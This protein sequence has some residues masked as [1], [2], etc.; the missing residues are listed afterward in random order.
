MPPSRLVFV[1]L[2]PLAVLMT[3]DEPARDVASARRPGTATRADTLPGAP[4]PEIVPRSGWH[5]DE[6]AAREHDSST[7]R[8]RTVF[9]HHTNQPN[10][11]DC[12]QVPRMLRMLEADHVRRGWDDLG[13]NFIV[14]RCGT[15]YEGR[16]GGL[17]GSVEGAH[18]KGFNAHSLGVAAL[19]SF[20]EGR[21]V[22]GAMV[23]SIA[24]LAAW[25][26]RPGIDPRGR[27]RMVSSSD[28][29]RFDKGHRARFHVISGHRDA[30]TTTC[31]GKALYGKLGEIRGKVERLRERARP[32]RPG[33]SSTEADSGER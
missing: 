6:E 15:I 31:P 8:V 14:D 18:T 29:S 21:R 26:L 1:A 10:D 24:A 30:Y 20:E 11:Y 4:R 22:P 32:R 25:K 7:G 23:D 5:A 9:I 17:D 27:T 16:A 28:A 3:W 33:P 12:S 2:L 19:G 13:Y